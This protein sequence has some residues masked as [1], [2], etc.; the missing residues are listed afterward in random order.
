MAGSSEGG[1]RVVSVW[2]WFSPIIVPPLCFFLLMGL[3]IAKMGWAWASTAPGWSVCQRTPTTSLSIPVTAELQSIWE[4][5]A[6]IVISLWRVLW[7][8][9]VACLGRARGSEDKKRRVR[10]GVSCG[11][12]TYHYV[13]L[14]SVRALLHS[15]LCMCLK[16]CCCFGVSGVPVRRWIRINEIPPSE[17]SKDWILLTYFFTPKQR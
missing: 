11:F 10:V 15:N 13:E 12:M 1:L 5:S 9:G 8:S 6:R 3:K 16:C 14:K 2:S 17:S 7:G 4:A